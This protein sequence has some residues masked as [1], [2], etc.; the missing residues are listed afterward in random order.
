MVSEEEITVLKSELT[1]AGADWQLHIYGRALHA[2]T[3]PE[4]NDPDFGTVYD[5]TTDRRSQ[6]SLKNVLTESFGE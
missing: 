6:E 2:F 4:A 3:N 5:A 1:K